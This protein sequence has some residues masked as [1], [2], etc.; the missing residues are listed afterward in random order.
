[1]NNDVNAVKIERSDCSFNRLPC[2]KQ[3][4]L[5]NLVFVG[6]IR[7]ICAKL[8]DNVHN[9]EFCAVGSSKFNGTCQRWLTL[10]KLIHGYQNVLQ[11]FICHDL[12]PAE[13][14]RSL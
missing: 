2:N 11:L 13:K 8:F 14:L 12:E 6:H 9:S 1:M 5:L 7:K 10:W 4:L 3:C